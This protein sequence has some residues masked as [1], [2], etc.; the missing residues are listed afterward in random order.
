MDVD[1]DV[2]VSASVSLNADVCS[3]FGS[4]T[5]VRNHVCKSANVSSERNIACT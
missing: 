1:V 3:C 4:S 5:Y 2:D